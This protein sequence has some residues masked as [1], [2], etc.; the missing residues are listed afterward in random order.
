MNGVQ[1]IQNMTEDNGGLFLRER[2]RLKLIFSRDVTGD[3][4]LRLFISDLYS[5]GVMQGGLA[6]LCSEFLDEGDMA[7]AENVMLHHG[8]DEDEIIIEIQLCG[9]A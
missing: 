1:T 3:P 8:M 4:N 7:L 5:T 6:C 2:G 9:L